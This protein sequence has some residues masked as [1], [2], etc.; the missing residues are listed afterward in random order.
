MDWGALLF[1][2]YLLTPLKSTM[3]KIIILMNASFGLPMMILL[4]IGRL[5]KIMFLWMD[6][7]RKMEFIADSA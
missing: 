2:H 1:G 6:T 3:R 4:V 7:V 5:M